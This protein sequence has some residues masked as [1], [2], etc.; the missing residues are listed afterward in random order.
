MY[1][2]FS[3]PSHLELLTVVQILKTKGNK[4]VK[5]ATDQMDVHVGAFRK[6]N[7]K[8]LSF[9]CNDKT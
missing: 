2:Y 3:H 7:D 6:N 9:A 5:N 1:G 8:I 4:I